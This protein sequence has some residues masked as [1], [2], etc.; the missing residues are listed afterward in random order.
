MRMITLTT[1]FGSEDWFVGTMKG[2][3]LS[4]NP[5]A[6]IVDVTHGIPPGDIRAGAFALASAYR[7]FPRHTVH[8]AVVDPGVG[9]NRAAIAVLTAD[10]VF[11][12]PD[13]GVL[14]LALFQEPMRSIRQLEH[15]RFFLPEVSRTFHGRDIFAPVAA[16]VSKGLSLEKL[17]RRLED[18][19]RLD[20]AEPR[21]NDQLLTGEVIYVDRFGNAITNISAKHL[22]AWTNS[23]LISAENRAGTRSTAFLTSHSSRQKKSVTQRH[24]SP[25]RSCEGLVVEI[26]RGARR[27]RIPFV[28]FYQ[29]VPKGRPLALIGSTGYLEIAVNG[30]D[31]AKRLHLRIGEGVSVRLDVA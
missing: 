14:S 10:H 19:Q 7:Y 21:A 29:A 11:I 3:I 13:N 20:F 26:K 9:S 28:D 22:D 23:R 8:L 6:V 5:R 24:P 27:P 4:L 1:D 30:G 17:G 18:Y 16:H 25:T 15:D 31:A 12:G 2:V